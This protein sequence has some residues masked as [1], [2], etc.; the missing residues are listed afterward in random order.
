[1]NGLSAEPGER[2]RCARS[3]CPDAAPIIRAAHIGEHVA[4]SVFDDNDGEAAAV[5]EIG[6]FAHGHAFDG[7]LQ[8]RI[9]RGDEKRCVWMGSLQTLRQMRG[10]E[11]HRHAHRGHAFPARHARVARR[12]DPFID[13]AR[14]HLVAALD[15]GK[16][17]TVGTI[18]ARAIAAARRGARIP[19]DRAP[20]AA[21]RNRRARLR[22]RLRDCRRM[23]PAS[24]RSKESRP[25]N[26]ALPAGSRAPSG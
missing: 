2:G 1:M 5:F 11:R 13:H 19:K 15:G 26:S 9:E 8:R 4:G 14:Q 10:C 6:A 18:F 24:D 12:H 16:A 21:F 25:S 22:A 7:G 3:I 23:A 17:M 20:T